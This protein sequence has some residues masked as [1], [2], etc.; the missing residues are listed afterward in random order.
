MAFTPIQEQK[1]GGLPFLWDRLLP[2]VSCFFR[3]F[4]RKGIARLLM[5]VKQR[6]EPELKIG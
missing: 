5:G 2:G 1:Y 3:Q 4:S 6:P